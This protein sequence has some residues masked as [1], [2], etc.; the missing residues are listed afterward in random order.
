LEEYPQRDTQGADGTSWIRLYPRFILENQRHLQTAGA[1]PVWIIL[2]GVVAL[3]ITF[4]LKRIDDSELA[5][6]VTI[7]LGLFSAPHLYGYDFVLALPLLLYL[8]REY[9]MRINVQG[10]P[11]WKY[12]RFTTPAVEREPESV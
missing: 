5:L 12:V 10:A 4:L 1:G 6:L 3:G 8:G 11:G 2:V 7:G 9:L